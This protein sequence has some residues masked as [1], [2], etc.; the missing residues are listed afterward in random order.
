MRLRSVWE[1]TCANCGADIITE[2]P[3]CWCR[4]CRVDFR[5]DW[6]APYQAKPEAPCLEP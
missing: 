6:E 3:E 4:N 5:I 1:L 2:I